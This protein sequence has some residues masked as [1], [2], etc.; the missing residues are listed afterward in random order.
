MTRW[1]LFASLAV[2]ACAQPDAAEGDHLI[3]HITCTSDFDGMVA[4]FDGASPQSVG[5]G[6]STQSFEWEDWEPLNGEDPTSISITVLA[7][8]NPVATGTALQIIYIDQ[9]DG[10]RRAEIS[11]PLTP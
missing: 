6:F 2:A 4:T 10:S 7:A 3:V 1:M 8:G 9:G 11:M 5:V